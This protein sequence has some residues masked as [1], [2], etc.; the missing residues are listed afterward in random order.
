MIA[1]TI[2]APLVWVRTV[3][4]ADS[5]NNPIESTA[6]CVASNP[7]TTIYVGLLVAFHILA[8]SFGAYV[9]TA[10]KEIPQEF[11]ESRWIALAMGSTLQIFLI[12]IPTVIATYTTSSFARYMSIM[13]IVF[14]TNIAMLL[15]IFVPKMLNE[16]AIFQESKNSS[17]SGN[18][19]HP[20]AK[21]GKFGVDVVA[22]P[23]SSA[24]VSGNLM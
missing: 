9:S 5:F 21:S 11:Q 16:Y 24:V 4:Y 15:F 13:L 18:S 1:W 3:T 23:N 22:V 10:A 8:L 17:A 20:S 2:D 14:V 7:N 19:S 12:G 6:A